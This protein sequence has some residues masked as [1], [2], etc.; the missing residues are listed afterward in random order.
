[1]HVLRISITVTSPRSYICQME[2]INDIRK[3]LMPNREHEES[4]ILQKTW[5]NQ[6]YFVC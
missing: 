1:M 4:L 6:V 3:H 5:Q 2:I